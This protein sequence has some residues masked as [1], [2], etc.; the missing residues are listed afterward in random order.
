MLPYYNLNIMQNLSI[1]SVDET[2]SLVRESLIEAVKKRVDNTDREIAC[3][4][5]GGLDSSLIS[6]LVSRELVNVHGRKSHKIYILG[7]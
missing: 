6:A 2:F 1:D 7:V 4:L 5:S 3:L